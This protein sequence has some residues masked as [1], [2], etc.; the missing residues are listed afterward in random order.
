M[1]IILYLHDAKD[2]TIKL[3]DIDILKSVV[4]A[5]SLLEQPIRS[6]NQDLLI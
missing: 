2:D 1:E 3:V 4:T 5:A 6:I